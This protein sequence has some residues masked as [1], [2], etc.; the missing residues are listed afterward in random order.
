[1]KETKVKYILVSDIA[2]IDDRDLTNYGDVLS[3]WWAMFKR[4][5]W[6]CGVPVKIPDAED[7]QLRVA[8]CLHY[9]NLEE[10][11]NDP[12]YEYICPAL[13]NFTARDVRFTRVRSL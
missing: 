13:G 11:K 8:F 3:G 5:I 1:M 9:R 6:P 12:N 4:T 10:L 2:A 7:I